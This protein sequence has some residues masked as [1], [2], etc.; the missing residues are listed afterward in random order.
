MRKPSLCLNMIVKNESAIID[1]CLAAVAP[2]VSA[3]VI[4]DTGSDDDTP[5]RVKRFF[6]ERG[7]P[8]ELHRIPFLN[9][10]QARNAAL[11][12]A[13]ASALDFEYLLFV[14]ADMELVVE[15]PEFA[16]GI[17]GRSYLLQQRNEIAYYN[18]RLLRRDTPARYVGVT[19]EY[20]DAGAP[21][22][23]LTGAWFVDHAAGANRVGKFERDARLLEDALLREPDNARY[24]FYLAQSQRD[25]G[26]LGTAR[27]TYVRRVGMGG[28]NEEVAYALFQVARI[29]E[30]LGA[31][32]DVI[33]RGL[34]DA[35]RARPTRVEPLVELA[36][37]CRLAGDW[38]DALLYARAAAIAERPDDLLFVD[39]ACY[40][41]RALDE[42]ALAGWYSGAHSEGRAAAARLLAENR[43]P[44]SERERIVANAKYYAIS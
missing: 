13:R 23:K 36:R 28:W 14:D 34:L 10:E 6:D 11:D 29:D 5:E 18:T 24:V 20:L 42:L 4:C 40:A 25:A 21:P 17:T 7:I 35:Y 1:R 38:A 43:F 12:L 16:N 9:F 27:E 26:A 19:H 44:A 30:R 37:L 39:E 22:E 8:G 33:R 41:W 2:L 3:W 32:S 15:D 31:P